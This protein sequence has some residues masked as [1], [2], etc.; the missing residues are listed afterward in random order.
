MNVVQVS[1]VQVIEVRLVAHGGM[2][3]FVGMLVLV[4]VVYGMWIA[5]CGAIPQS[6]A[7]TLSAPEAAI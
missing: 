2:S 6:G 1:I 3:T 4:T 7:L 5:H